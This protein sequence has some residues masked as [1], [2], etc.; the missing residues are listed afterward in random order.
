MDPDQP[1]HLRSLIR[2]HAVRLPT[3]LE[4]EKMIANS[5]DPD[6]TPRMRRLVTNTLCWFCHDAAQLQKFDYI[7]VCDIKQMNLNSIF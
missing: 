7:N 5:M 6:Q 3:L 1:V 4:V 2:I